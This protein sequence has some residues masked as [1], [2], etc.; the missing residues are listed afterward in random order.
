MRRARTAAPLTALTLALLLPQAAHATPPTGVS[1]V[2]VAKTTHA[3]RDYVVR[4]ITIGPGGGTGWHFHRGTLYARV[5]VGTLTH[6]AADCVTIRTY[7]AGD[8][9]VEPSGPQHVHMG[10]NRGPGPLV[11]DVLYVNP[12]GSALSEDA[13]APPCAA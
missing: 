4:E 3:G 13:P 7:H 10:E 1:S 12:A 8:S 2:I 5:R 11:L 9:L 6:T